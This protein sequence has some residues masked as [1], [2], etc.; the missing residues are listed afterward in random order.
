MKAAFQLQHEMRLSTF[1]EVLKVRA[2]ILEM[3]GFVVMLCG[4]S[5]WKQAI[6]FLFFVAGWVAEWFINRAS[7]PDEAQQSPNQGE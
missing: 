1:A 5:L 7:R 6:G 2:N 4:D 3:G